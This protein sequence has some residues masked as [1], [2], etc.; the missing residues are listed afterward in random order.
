MIE[1]IVVF[2]IDIKFIKFDY[3]IILILYI[4]YI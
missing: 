4:G 2:I 3:G 1:S